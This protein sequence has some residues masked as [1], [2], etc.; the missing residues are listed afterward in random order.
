MSPDA[1][2]PRDRSI[3]R[4]VCARA[5]ARYLSLAHSLT[6]SLT[7]SLSLSRFLFFFSNFEMLRVMLGE[8]I[9]TADVGARRKNS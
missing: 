4:V 7:H 1:K 2:S 8:P 6:H 9:A 3:G 5:R